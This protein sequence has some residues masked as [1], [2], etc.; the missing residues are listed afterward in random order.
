MSQT[1][2]AGYQQQAQAAQTS[3][4]EL[5][6]EINSYSLMRLG[7]FGSVAV[8]VYLS[9][10]TTGIALF[11]SLCAVL[12]AV[13]VW[14][15]A[16][17]SKLEQ[18]R[19]YHRA[20]K[21]VT[22]N[23][24]RS[25]TDRGNIYD[26]G[27][28]YANDKHHYTSDLDIFGKLSLYQLTNR[29]ATLPGKDVLAAWL[30]S[31]STK[32]NIL[33]RQQAVKEIA[34]KNDLKLDL[35]AR[36]LFANSSG[37]GQLDKL[38]VYLT[39]PLHLPGEQ[40]LR[41]YVKLAPYLLAGSILAA[42]YVPLVTLLA[43]ALG[44]F[45]MGVLVSRGGF[46]A[47][48]GFVADK[49]GQV[50]G[51]YADVF[52]VLENEQWASEGCKVL[53][54]KLKINGTSKRIAQLSI[55]IN[56]LSYSLIMVVGFIL[57]VFFL[58][59]LKQIIAIEDWKRDNKDSLEDAFNVIGEFEALMGLAGL[60]K[61]FPDW[62]FPTI[63]AGDGY[64]YKAT[65]IAHPLIAPGIS[66]AND[67][68]LSDTYKVD[69]ITGSNMAGKSTFLRTVGINAV[70]GL[71]GAPV[72]ADSL[73][74]SVIRVITYMRIK[75]SLNESTSTFKAELDR[76]QMLL[77]AV[78]HDEKVYFLI[79]E[80]LRGTNSVDKY[81]GSKAV[82]KQLIA[83]RG[84]GQ[85]ATHDLQIARLEDEYPDYVRNYYFDI[86]VQDGE[87]LFDYRIK[88]GECKTFNA[89]MLLKRIGIDVA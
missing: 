83:K 34:A 52:K 55:L 41:T 74:L 58:W 12:L 60:H 80:M 36:L 68:E 70:L 8:A 23:E 27:S 35:Q 40:W 17:Q 61:N 51:N 63:A 50:L 2:I 14:L 42:V 66:V 71:C 15:V 45:N 37:A 85:V 21:T 24:I 43:V 11:P 31:P 16:K 86:Q 49:I 32:E 26:N 84:V 3:I 19:E 57:N 77:A 46:I 87:M 20:L 33:T 79:D 54:D 62:T 6:K 5:S 25:L 75:D 64:T 22:E 72:C 9:M 76:L 67:F 44:I 48:S 29:A 7:V 89:S 47:K 18:Q 73:E 88:H 82:I 10:Q 59:A 38:F 39:T 81:L 65:N 53:A 78:E 28:A 1:I 69:I 30:S 56:K 13:F 4:D